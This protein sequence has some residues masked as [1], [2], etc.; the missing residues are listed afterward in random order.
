MGLSCVQQV[1]T[2]PQVSIN[3]PADTGLYV[4]FAFAGSAQLYRL[5]NA[6]DR[7]RDLVVRVY[8][9]TFTS[10]LYCS[11]YIM[12]VIHADVTVGGTCIMCDLKFEDMP[13][14]LV[15]ADRTWFKD[16]VFEVRLR[17]DIPL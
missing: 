7:L 5:H 12:D 10:A 3:V 17:R 13:R 16:M 4:D 11:E 15:P 8:A 1:F 9:P 14:Y 6:Q 2:E